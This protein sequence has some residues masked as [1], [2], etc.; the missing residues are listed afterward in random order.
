MKK[1]ILI[2][3]F[4]A[5]LVATS[6]CNT[7]D[8]IGSV[9]VDTT[10][11]PVTTT[12][13]LINYQN[14][15]PS[16]NVYQD[17][18]NQYQELLTL[19]KNNA[20]YE[21]IYLSSNEEGN[22]I[23]SAVYHAILCNNPEKM[24]YAMKDLNG[25]GVDE[26]ILLNEDYHIYAIFTA[27]NGKSVLV[28]A[29]FY[30]DVNDTGA[31]GPDGTIYKHGYGKGENVYGYSMKLSDDGSL[32][33]TEFGCSDVDI[34]DSEVDY[35]KIVNGVRESIDYDEFRRLNDAYYETVGNA[36]DLTK[37]SCDD[38]VRMKIK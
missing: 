23:Q 33:G 29:S 2:L 18:I 3:L 24:G 8:D 22:E 19:K 16:E 7:S 5:I 26:L 6:S 25:D 38:F 9:N 36:T 17:V 11:V 21:K 10:T 15:Q 14:K 12:S 13:N 32:C 27:V 35:Y 4:C 37:Q 34:D 31:I 1:T 30:G 28:D 20:N